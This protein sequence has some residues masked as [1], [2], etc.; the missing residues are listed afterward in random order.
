M[1]LLW[2]LQLRVPVLTRQVFSLRESQPD[3]CPLHLCQTQWELSASAEVV[4]DA[5]KSGKREKEPL[6]PSRSLHTP[7]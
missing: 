1:L 3:W 7:I 6:E 2:K 4:Q 5:A